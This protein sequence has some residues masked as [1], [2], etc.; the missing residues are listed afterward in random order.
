MAEPAEAA[1]ASEYGRLEYADGFAWLWLDE[2]GRKINTLSG[3]FLAWFEAVLSTLEAE[4]PRHGLVILSAKADCFVAGADVDELWRSSDA[5]EVRR[6]L[7]QGH[8]LL[9]RIELMPFP[10]V[11]AIHGACLGGGLELALA[12]D[13]RVASESEVTR[14]G[15]PEV[16]LG[17]IPG[18]GGSQRLPRLI[19][20]ARALPLILTGKRLR[21]SK[22]LALGL[23][24]AACH[25]GQL[26]EVAAQQAVERAAAGRRAGRTRSLSWRASDLAA[27]LPLTR[28]WIFARARK[29]VRTKTQGH[30][31]AP[32]AAID[33][34]ERGLALPLQEAL[35]VE[36]EAFSQLA[37]SRTA[38][39]LMS[40]FFSKTQV[41]TK[42]SR[43]AKEA[44]PVSRVGV[45]GAGFMGAG[46]AQVL[47]S[48]KLSV[49]LKDRDLATVG[50]GLARCRERFDQMVARRRYR[51]N[52]AAEAMARI[53]ATQDYTLLGRC[54]LV[55]E[56]VVEELAV[57][58]AV[59]RQLEAVAR[60]DQI[61][62]SNTS[63][64]PIARIAVASQRPEQVVGM[65]FF[66]PVH[67]MPL[68]EVIAHPGSA[69]SAVATAIE[70]GR[71]MGKTV[72]VVQDGAGFFTSRVL[73]PF[74]NEA[75][76]CL[77]QG[78]SI[79]EVDRALTRWGWPVGPLALLDEVGLDI[80]A[81]S[82]EVLQ[83]EM[84]DRFAA[85]ELFARLLREGRTG[86]KGKGGFYDYSGANKKADRKVYKLIDWKP[87]P[88]AEQEIAERCWMQM[89]NETARAIE[90]GVIEDPVDI[91]L[92][93]VFGFGFPPFRGGLLREADR[94][95]AGYVV[96]RLDS[97]A[98]VY[99][100]RLRPAELLRR[101]ADRGER[102][103]QR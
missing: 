101:M 25:P 84:G 42:A 61:F 3:R 65:H 75:A 80:A 100:E 92:A 35:E 2:P 38:K 83:A 10:T 43:W 56:A 33:V 62:A 45:L 99:G 27:R 72:I 8:A 74:L 70:V 102:F 4:P 60:E 85:P 32:L 31:P 6:L 77:V 79:E 95:G 29:R 36:A 52:E 68:V 17:L 46:V 50:Q 23:I 91:D 96:D 98:E 37:V 87:A 26:Q 90:D 55:I 94:L 39:A 47:S 19:G 93:V 16:Q 24:D 54:E 1:A 48:A 9:R 51:P 13:R 64:L 63:T 67:K 81:H 58:Q 12:C 86:R 22:A 5:G 15:L 40:I 71:R 21:A 89:L 59:L 88:I 34:M 57:K 49:V 73:A 69:A 66:S 78:G 7:R 14:L 97:W 18:L 11:A 20:V 41:E 53:Q 103:H 28:W 30:Y 76:W 44:R 82:A